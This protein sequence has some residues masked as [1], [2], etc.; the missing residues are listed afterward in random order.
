MEQPKI[1][2]IKDLKKKQ[3]VV[4]FVQEGDQVIVFVSKK[5]KMAAI[6]KQILD[7]KSPWKESDVIP[8]VVKTGVLKKKETDVI[9]TGEF[10]A[11][12]A[13]RTKYRPV[14]GGCEI[15]P[16][17][18]T[19]VGTGGAVVK[20][21]ET[22]EPIELNWFQKLIY[23]IL[24]ALNFQKLIDDL[25]W[26][27]PAELEI[28]YLLT[29]AHVTQDDVDDPTVD[30]EIVQPGTTASEIGYV[31]DSTRINPEAE[32]EI[33][34]SIIRLTVAAESKMVNGAV[35]NG[36]REGNAGEKAIKYGRTTRLTSGT[37]KNKNVSVSINYG[38]PTGIVWFKGC[39]MYSY[40]SDAGDSGSVILAASDLAAI[41][42]LFAG[43]ST[44]T[45]A[46]PIP[47]VMQRFNIQI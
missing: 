22:G 30:Q 17:G 33:D 25:G 38:A 45:I 26:E 46:I 32:N 31:A 10:K 14:I 15:S 36:F 18:R 41:S 40:M 1:G 9:E 4:G 12:A 42:L 37:L 43:S 44:T 11:L 24:K 5:L 28:N 34:A 16:L 47:K 3:N 29:N 19:W 39:D 7:P 21:K 2:K 27:Q 8:K 20:K 6:E 13:D 23:L 35:P